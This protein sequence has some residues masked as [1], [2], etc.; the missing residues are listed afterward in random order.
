MSD[1]HGTTNLKQVIAF[2]T[3]VVKEAIEIDSNKDGKISVFEGLSIATSIAPG[4]PAFQSAIPHIKNE[5]RDLDQEEQAD[6]VNYF[7]EQFELPRHEDIEEI[8]E[9]IVNQL[10]SG[11]QAFQRLREL[12]A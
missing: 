9:L 4:Y 8:V 7:A 6:L 10:F 2:V 11:I 12:L 3:K 1:E 5:F